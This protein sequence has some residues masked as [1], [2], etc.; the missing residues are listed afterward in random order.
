MKNPDAYAL[1]RELRAFADRYPSLPILRKDL[2]AAAMDL[3]ASTYN[4]MGGGGE[5]II[6]RGG[7]G[8]PCCNDPDC[9][10]MKDATPTLATDAMVERAAKALQQV[11]DCS[12]LLWD[13]LPDYGKDRL[14][15][16]ARAALTA[17]LA[18]NKPAGED[19]R[20]HMVDSYLNCTRQAQAQGSE[21]AHAQAGEGSNG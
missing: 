9:G 20:G 8:Y 2:Y 6:A 13:E 10:Y 5:P 4:E 15:D 11:N 12:L 16:Q 21:A 18:A 19:L 3:E 17:A 14:R 1:A 7:C